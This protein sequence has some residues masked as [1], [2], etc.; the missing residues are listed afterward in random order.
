MSTGGYP[1]AAARGGGWYGGIQLSNQFRKNPKLFSENFVVIKNQS[2][3]LI[4]IY[5]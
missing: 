3:M 2:V 5:K 4:Q 1:P